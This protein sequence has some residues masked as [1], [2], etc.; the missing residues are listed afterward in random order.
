MTIGMLTVDSVE[1]VLG[2][3]RAVRLGRTELV[4]AGPE[5]RFV[6]LLME[7]FPLTF[8]RLRNGLLSQTKSAAGRKTSVGYNE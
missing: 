4:L 5:L 7:S 1:Q 3:Q 6:L 2:R 8:L